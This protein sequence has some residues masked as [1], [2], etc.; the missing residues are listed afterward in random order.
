MNWETRYADKVSTAENALRKIKNG[1]NLFIHTGC[2]EPQTL[3]G[4]LERI[5]RDLVDTCVYHVANLGDSPYARKEYVECLRLKTFFI[6]PQAR[7]AVAEGRA[8]YI[9]VRSSDVPALFKQGII[10]LDM[11]LIQVSPPD[12]HGFCSLGISV[13]VS[14]AA[15]ESAKIIV[16]E[17]N[18]NMPRT[19]GDSFLHV[20]QIDFLVKGNDPLITVVTKEP[21]I[22]T[23]RIGRHLSQLV[24]D[25]DTI[26][27][28]YGTV[29]NAALAFL[30]DKKDLGI[31]TEF[32]TTG[33]AELAEAGVI[34][35]RKK[36]LHPGK[37]VAC[38]CMGDEWLYKF[39]DNNPMLEFLPSDYVCD[40]H[41]ISLND[42]M[43]AINSALQVDLTG[44]VCVDSI[45][46]KFFSG[47]GGTLD[48]TDGGSKSKNGRAIIALPSTAK[49]GTVSRIVPKLKEGS[50]VAVPRSDIHY[51]VT[52]YGTAY[53][54]GRTIFERS[55]QLINIAHP[56]FRQRLMLAAKKQHYI[57]A[58][59]L[60]PSS[61]DNYPEQLEIIRSF[62]NGVPV[63][64]RPIK[65][66]DET[67]LRD[68]FYTM[69][70]EAIYLRYFHV[71]REA[72]HSR[73]QQL[74]NIDYHQEM[75]IV[76]ITEYRGYPEIIAVALYHLDLESN[77]AEV[78]FAI[79]DTWHGFGIGTFLLK[80][81]ATIA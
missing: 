20:D 42:N 32:F 35:N 1:D 17:V 70:D 29:P 13:D 8:D 4:Y 81:L 51:V 69:S 50:G 38:M 12:H 62:K 66:V 78:S 30:R 41:V 59:Q 21:D 48:F 56:R 43:V 60:P 57:F 2:A 22:I 37:M 73:M 68:L 34:T 40:P 39:V 14:K 61:V 58:D 11:A 19:L 44:Q 77:A 6:G 72:P 53:L 15:A 63:F 7:E 52:E 79:H 9:P 36:T 10:R 49:N 54:F 24:R 67:M 47:V 75:T 25:G 5:G 16:A 3:T 18:P 31:H 28:G 27:V 74:V 23:Q 64:F 33:I 71:V 55:L 45:G 26:E 65:P 76:G 80:Y 46:H